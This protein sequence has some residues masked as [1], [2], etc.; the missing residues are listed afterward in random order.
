VFKRENCLIKLNQLFQ[1]SC[2]QAIRMM[3]IAVSLVS[4]QSYA[5]EL[6]LI[7]S[8]KAPTMCLQN[9]DNLQLQPCDPQNEKQRWD[10]LK[11]SGGIFTA[12]STYGW[13]VYIDTQLG[14]TR[15]AGLVWPPGSSA[16]AS[17]LVMQDSQRKNL[18]LGLYQEKTAAGTMVQFQ[19]CKDWLG[20]TKEHNQW[21]TEKV[22]LPPPIPPGEA[23]SAGNFICLGHNYQ[24]QFA[25]KVSLEQIEKTGGELRGARPASGYDSRFIRTARFCT[26]PQELMSGDLV[27]VKIP[28]NTILCQGSQPCESFATDNKVFLKLHASS[29]VQNYVA[30]L[31]QVSG[32]QWPEFFIQ[33]NG[34]FKAIERRTVPNHLGRDLFTL[35]QVTASVLQPDVMNPGRIIDI[36][37]TAEN[38]RPQA[39]HTHFA[40]GTTR[41][42]EFSPLSSMSASQVTAQCGTTNIKGTMGQGVDGGIDLSVRFR[43]G[44]YC[45]DKDTFYLR[46]SP[47]VRQRV[48]KETS[49]NF[50][51][52]FAICRGDA[53]KDA[54]KNFENIIAEPNTHTLKIARSQPDNKLLQGILGDG[55]HWRAP[56]H[57]RPCKLFK[58]YP[59]PDGSFECRDQWGSP[60]CKFESLWEGSNF[61]W[62]YQLYDYSGTGGP[63]SPDAI[64]NYHYMQLLGAFLYDP[65][66]IQPPPT[67]APPPLTPIQPPSLPPV[68]PPPTPST[69]QTI[70]NSTGRRTELGV[71]QSY[72]RPNYGNLIPNPRGF[73][74]WEKDVGAGLQNHDWD[75]PAAIHWRKIDQNALFH[76]HPDR[77]HYYPDGW[78]PVINSDSEFTYRISTMDIVALIRAQGYSDEADKFVYELKPGHQQCEL[79]LVSYTN[80]VPS[81][82]KKYVLK[83]NKGEEFVNRGTIDY[84][85]EGALS[86]SEVENF[87]NQTITGTQA[88][89]GIEFGARVECQIPGIKK[90]N[91]TENFRYHTKQRNF[92]WQKDSPVFF[93]SSKNDG[94]ENSLFK[95]DWQFSL[96]FDSRGRWGSN[97][98]LMVPFSRVPPYAANP[99]QAELNKLMLCPDN[100]CAL[101]NIYFAPDIG[102]GAVFNRLKRSLP[103]NQ[104]FYSTS[105]KSINEV[106]NTTELNFNVGFFF[107]YEL[108]YGAGDVLRYTGSNKTDTVPRS[109]GPVW[110]A[111]NSQRAKNYLRKLRPNVDP[112]ILE[113]RWLERQQYLRSK[114]FDNQSISR[115]LAYCQVDPAFPDR[116]GYARYGFPLDPNG[117]LNDLARDPDGK[118]AW[119][120]TPTASETPKV[121][122]P[123]TLPPGETCNQNLAPTCS[124]NPRFSKMRFGAYYF[125]D[126][127]TSARPEPFNIYLKE[128]ATYVIGER[129]DQPKFSGNY[130]I[131]G[132]KIHFQNLAK[133]G[134]FTQ[135]NQLVMDSFLPNLTGV[136]KVF[137]C[138]G[139]ACRSEAEV[140]PAAKLC[141]AVFKKVDP[142]PAVKNPDEIKG[143]QEE[144]QT[145]LPKGGIIKLPQSAEDVKIIPKLQPIAPPKVDEPLRPVAPPRMV[146]TPNP[147]PP[148]PSSA[149][150]DTGIQQNRP[151]PEL[152]RP[153]LVTPPPPAPPV[154]PSAPPPENRPVPVAKPE[155]A[156]PP[157]KPAAPPAKKEPEFSV[158]IAR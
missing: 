81:N 83:Q 70:L 42:V 120:D 84:Y 55:R 36:Y 60:G 35:F 93:L 88:R 26:N 109:F 96:A 68:A 92:I 86:A 132:D 45:S 63:T 134:T 62:A 152:P 78:I 136:P 9:G 74:G 116:F 25:D 64:V 53:F 94:L 122:P 106:L 22:N 114:D 46:S 113:S 143:V 125:R 14:M 147:I 39:R 59:L 121:D 33:E 102:G 145:E 133:V 61:I 48:V 51:Y 11:E 155:P 3:L 119:L 79:N 89:Q 28:A 34:K 72:L 108:N 148:P 87:L 151:V 2:H 65:Q 126:S 21:T 141:Q 149:P 90:G 131:C 23:V 80:G 8:A 58:S 71:R 98:G 99:W 112:K 52:G 57:E 66:K 82:P 137:L 6:Y 41:L 54:I 4:F 49:S 40:L 19:E 50:E 69:I 1:M 18:C 95:L 16:V 130:F 117:V 32:S 13:N 97:G 111:P 129:E 146:P 135:N 104:E 27:F 44:S 100:K 91:V 7:K 56:N 5:Q 17:K 30:P 20:K 153:I 140:H 158:P 157:A 105:N 103:M 12:G 123:K 24:S 15:N 138:T 156:P 29:R 142:P 127:A 73:G 150:R 128:N 47:F 31:I 144:K 76:N 118:C 10:I 101:M 107:T 67:P 43:A 75:V 38:H 115:T 37:A 139:T 124:T 110:A 77:N 85:F 154:R